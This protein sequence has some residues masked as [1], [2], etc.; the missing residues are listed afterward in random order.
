M[1][2]R[3]KLSYLQR[4]ACFITVPDEIVALVTDQKYGGLWSELQFFTASYTVS[5]ER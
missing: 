2:T 4:S 5:R 3:K 1:Y